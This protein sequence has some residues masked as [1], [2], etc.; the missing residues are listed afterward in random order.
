MAC[1]C[2]SQGFLFEFCSFVCADM[3]A[4]KRVCEKK[5]DGDGTVVSAFHRVHRLF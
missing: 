1:F 3:S 4:K 5:A 2:D